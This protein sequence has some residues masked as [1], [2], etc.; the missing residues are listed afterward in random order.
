M[1]NGR[2][3]RTTNLLMPASV[4]IVHDSPEFL[5][6]AASALRDAGYDVTCHCS[7]LAAIDDVEAGARIDVLV[8]GVA[9]PP[10][11]PHGISLTHMLR[12]RRRGLPVVLIGNG[13]KFQAE[14]ASVG[15]LV[16]LAVAANEL[17][18]TVARVIRKA[19]GVRGRAYC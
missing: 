11:S 5:A 19:L 6:G 12:A 17:T 3:A 8:T 15:E 9:F 4:V 7:P 1:F 14:A 10:G 2:I 18:T 13:D 16:P